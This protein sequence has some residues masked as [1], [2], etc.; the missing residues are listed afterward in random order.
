MSLPGL[1]CECGWKK[2]GMR[3]INNQDQDLLITIEKEVMRGG[4][5][6]RVLGDRIKE[7]TEKTPVLYVVVKKSVDGH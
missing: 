6:T 5:S 4:G 7:S 2:T 1:T 3:L